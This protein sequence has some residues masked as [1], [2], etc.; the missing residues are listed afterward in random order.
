MHVGPFEHLLVGK[1]SVSYTAN[2]NF[3]T[4]RSCEKKAWKKKSGLLGFEPSTI[5]VKTSAQTNTANKPTG[6]VITWFVI[7][8]EK[9]IRISLYYI[10]RP[11]CIYVACVNSLRIHI[12]ENY[13]NSHPSHINW[14]KI[15]RK[16][17]ETTR[18]YMYFTSE[19]FAAIVVET[20]FNRV[21]VP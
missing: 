15:I 6:V 13:F 14:V 1:W 21:Y 4:V 17:F 12:Q 5:P 7:Y 20:S 11:S 16:K 8:R 2:E 18:R 3:F 19:F 9:K 10:L